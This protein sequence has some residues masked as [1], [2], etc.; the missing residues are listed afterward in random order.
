MLLQVYMVRVGIG[1]RTLWK[2]MID[3]FLGGD[4]LCGAFLVR[5]MNMTWISHVVENFC[6]VRAQ[7]GASQPDSC[8]KL[9]QVE[10]VSLSHL[11]Y[12]QRL[13]ELIDGSPNPDIGGKS[14]IVTDP[15]PPPT[16]GDVYTAL[17]TLTNGET[18]FKPLS[19]TTML[20]VAHVIET[21]YLLREILTMSSWRIARLMAVLFPRISGEL[22]NLQPS[23]WNLTMA[24]CPQSCLLDNS[25]W[26]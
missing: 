5:R 26:S 25:S 22:V 8:S 6:A 16:Y 17:S 23:L 18:T 24:S 4:I 21:I 20:L 15:G 9:L 10:V 12:E 11:C 14:F 1:K 19:S 7:C 2:T 3:V 13:V